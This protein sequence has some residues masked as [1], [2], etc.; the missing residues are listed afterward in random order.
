MVIDGEF[1]GQSRGFD[2]AIFLYGEDE[3]LCIAALRQGRRVV[4]IDT[5]PIV[6]DFG[7]GR[8]RFNRTI[9]DLKYVSLVYFI[10][11]NVRSPL[12]RALMTL[13]LPFHVYGFQRFFYAFN[14]KGKRCIGI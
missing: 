4:T 6:H 9:A 5:M 11:K 14:N 1:L 10:R 12:N 8:N 13:L 3:D 7:W 2:P